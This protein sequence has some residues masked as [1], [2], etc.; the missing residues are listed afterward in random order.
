M[1]SKTALN[2]ATGGSEMHLAGAELVLVGS[3]GFAQRLAVRL[4][5]VAEA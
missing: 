5:G 4:A 2:A 3:K 1:A